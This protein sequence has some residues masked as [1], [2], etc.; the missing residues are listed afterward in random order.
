MSAAVLPGISLVFAVLLAVLWL[1]AWRLVAAKKSGDAGAGEMRRNAAVFFAGSLV[2]ASGVSCR[3]CIV[4]TLFLAVSFETYQM[5]LMGLNAASHGL[6]VVAVLSYIGT[7]VISA[8]RGQKKQSSNN[9]GY[10]PLTEEETVP[11][12]YQI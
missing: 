7:A 12:A 6:T 2:L 3:E 8:A 5:P 1:V 9:G 4:A 11:Q 10:V